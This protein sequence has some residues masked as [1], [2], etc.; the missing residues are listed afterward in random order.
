MSDEEEFAFGTSELNGVKCPVAS[1][2]RELLPACSPV[3]ERYD[4]LA[5]KETNEA[6][7]V[8]G[9]EQAKELFVQALE[10]YR[11]SLERIGDTPEIDVCFTMARR[12]A[13]KHGWTNQ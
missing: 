4:R 3:T 6:R 9:R 7:G 1:I 11:G 2:D 8:L 10:D 12:V 5:E 13:V